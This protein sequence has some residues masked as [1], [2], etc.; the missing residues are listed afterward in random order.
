MELQISTCQ[1]EASWVD[2][3]NGNVSGLGCTHIGHME[4]E[5]FDVHGFRK[6]IL[7][8]DVEME[9][10]LWVMTCLRELQVTTIH[11]EKCCSHLVDMIANPT[12][13]RAFASKLVLFHLIQGNF[14]F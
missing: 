1:I 2:H 13:W 9:G 6:S 14:G 8:L 3:G 4:V 11:I 10:L 7:A 5:R 12:I